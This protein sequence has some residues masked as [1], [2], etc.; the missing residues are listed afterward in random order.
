MLQKA[1]ERDKRKYEFRI[2]IDVQKSLRLSTYL[3]NNPDTSADS[4]DWP[5][6]EPKEKAP[7]DGEEKIFDIHFEKIWFDCNQDFL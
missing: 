7:N 6:D 1:V 3:K 4:C 5:G 2:R